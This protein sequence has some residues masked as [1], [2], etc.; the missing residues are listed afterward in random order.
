MKRL[1]SAQEKYSV[2]NVAVESRL[3]YKSQTSLVE[4]KT[5]G[6]NSSTI[7]DGRNSSAINDVDMEV[8]SSEDEI[9]HIPNPNHELSLQERL[10]NL[11]GIQLPIPG[12][13]PPHDPFDQQP[14]H[15]HQQPPPQKE[16]LQPPPHGKTFFQKVKFHGTQY[17][18]CKIIFQP[19]CP[20]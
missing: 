1:C 9:E 4:V 16:H 10:S 5:D 6:R 14:Q 19:A 8:V 12:L 17:K 2:L 3:Q 13:S 18:V 11:A 20:F 15:Q 7:N